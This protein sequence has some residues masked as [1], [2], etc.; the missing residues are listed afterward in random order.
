MF[1]H[2]VRFNDFGHLLVSCSCET[3]ETNVTVI[4]EGVIFPDVLIQQSE[5]IKTGTISAGI[6]NILILHRVTLGEGAPEATPSHIH[7]DKS[8]DK[9]E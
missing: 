2:H 1:F 6:D 4:L 3:L 5:S 9:K 7:C 8:C